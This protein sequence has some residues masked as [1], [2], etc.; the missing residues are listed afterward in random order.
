[1]RSLFLIGLAVLLQACTVMPAG[2]VGSAGYGGDR[3]DLATWTATGRIH[4]QAD[5]ES[6]QATLYWRQ[7]DD[8]YRIRL[9]APLGQGTVELR[10]D[11]G[12]VILRTTKGEEYAAADPETLMT[13]TLGW[14]VPVDGMRFWMVGRVA[15]GRTVERRRVNEAG[16]LTEFEQSGWRIRYLRY[17]AESG[18]ALPAKLVLETPR[19]SIRVVVSRWE[20]GRA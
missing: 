9:I 11:A 13:D 20:P 7:A 16:L 14:R 12:G 6:W 2:Q 19:F 5:E 17:S 3:A 1:M 4:I 15:P 18:I 10:G 8:R